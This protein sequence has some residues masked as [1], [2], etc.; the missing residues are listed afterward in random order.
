MWSPYV[1][2]KL[3]V[4]ILYLWQQFLGDLCS[5]LNPH[6]TKQKD[7]PFKMLNTSMENINAKISMVEIGVNLSRMRFC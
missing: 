4:K 6:P 5:A 3:N 1:N 7:D 2:K